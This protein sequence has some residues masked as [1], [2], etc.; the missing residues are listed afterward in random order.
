MMNDIISQ[1]VTSTE[2]IDD[3][4]LRQELDDLLSAHADSN[5]FTTPV[6]PQFESFSKHECCKWD[7]ENWCFILFGFAMHWA[8]FLVVYQHLTFFSL[9]KVI[10]HV[11]TRGPIYKISYDNLTIILR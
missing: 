2:T 7:F 11:D 10:C 1:P 5:I 9:N 6:R 3:D 8:S 4:E